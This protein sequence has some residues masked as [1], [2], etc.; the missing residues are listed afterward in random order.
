PRPATMS[1]GSNIF[2]P[3]GLRNSTSTT[4]TI[5]KSAQTLKS[6]TA[7]REVQA[8]GRMRI[9][10]GKQNATT[11]SGAQL[12]TNP[13]KP[14]CDILGRATSWT[15]GSSRAGANAIIA[16][17]MFLLMSTLHGIR[18]LQKSVYVADKQTLHG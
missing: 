3:N 2:F 5:V 9:E 18:C 12:S 8:R 6:L 11:K 17:M 16:G 13:S 14:A 10:N 4:A 15:R 1:A 7:T